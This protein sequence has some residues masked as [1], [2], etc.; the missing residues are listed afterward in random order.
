MVDPAKKMDS[1]CA[2]LNANIVK[3]SE[4]VVGRTRNSTDFWGETTR[5]SLSPSTRFWSIQSCK[6]SQTH[7]NLRNFKQPRTGAV[8][9]VH[10]SGIN[11]EEYMVNYLMQHI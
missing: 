4:G 6:T 3:H 11:N 9:A 8:H 5:G 2:A 10:T 1:T 7:M